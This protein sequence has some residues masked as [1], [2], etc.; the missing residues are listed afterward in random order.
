MIESLMIQTKI[1]TI[2]LIAFHYNFDKIGIIEKRVFVKKYILPF[3][4]LVIF[5][6]GCSKN[7]TDHSNIAP[8]TIST[9]AWIGYAPLY[10]AKEK[11]YLKPL[12][13]QLIVN[14]SLAEA[15]DVYLMGNADIVSTTQHEYHTIQKSVPDTVPFI[16]LD[17]SDGGDMILSNKSLEMIRQ[18]KHIYAYLEIDSINADLLQDFIRFHHLDTKHFTFINKDQAQIQNLRPDPS[19]T[20]LVV[21]YSPYDST[22]KKAGFKVLSS[23]RSTKELVVID[24]LCTHKTLLKTQKQ[25]FNALKKVIDRAIKEIETDPKGSYALIKGYLG[26]LSYTDYINAFSGIR[27]IN[28]PSDTLLQRIRSIG[29]NREYIIP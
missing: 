2:L 28:H 18:A 26:N 9:N 5:F 11:G 23:T 24:A 21:T 13:M 27:W 20:I 19:K 12:N 7:G 14:V 22:L 15:A 29:Y 16:L 3:L 4:L 8:L 17:R 25:R 1:Q 10:Y 6:T